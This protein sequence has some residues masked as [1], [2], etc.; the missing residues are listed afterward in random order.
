MPKPSR[1][2]SL[3]GKLIDLI[4]NSEDDLLRQLNGREITRFDGSKVKL[5]LANPVRIPFELSAR[6]K[7]LSR[8]VQPDVFLHPINPWCSRPVYR[9]HPSRVIAPGVVGGICMVLALYAMHIF[10]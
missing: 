2:R 3:D 9:I 10:P 4:A 7:F 1:K 6:Q 5:A 8:I